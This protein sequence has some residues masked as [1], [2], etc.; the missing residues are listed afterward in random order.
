MSV[1]ESIRVEYSAAVR[2]LVATLNDVGPIITAD[3]APPGADAAPDPLD[4]AIDRYTS[5]SNDVFNSARTD[6]PNV[7]FAAIAGDLRTL[8]HLSERLDGLALTAAVA[9]GPG[10]A[11]DMADVTTAVTT[12]SLPPGPVEVTMSADTVSPIDS[13]KASIEAIA[14]KGYASVKAVAT[15]GVVA[16]T[17]AEIGAAAGELFGASTGETIQAG[18]A[19]LTGFLN[20]IK[21]AVA[22]L[23]KAVLDKLTSLFGQATVDK[24]TDWLK[25]LADPGAIFSRIV[26]VPALEAKA[27]AVLPTATNAADCATKIAA[28]SAANT[29]AERWVGWGATALGW[30]NPVVGKLVPW[31]PIALRSVWAGLILAAGLITVDHLDSPNFDWLPSLAPGVGSILDQCS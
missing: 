8:Q 21:R 12:G 9:P 1:S 25:Q 31:G 6:Q 10:F 23:L 22:K 2:N 29:T 5:A 7:A 14:D 4:A 30:A 26:G 13:V 11:D 27:V 16:L 17:G 19:A 28:I 15:T 20:R 24:W 18:I 3:I